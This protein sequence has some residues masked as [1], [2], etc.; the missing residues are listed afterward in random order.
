MPLCSAA[1]SSLHQRSRRCRHRRRR[2]RFSRIDP[3]AQARTYSAT[4]ECGAIRRTAAYP[5]QLDRG[6]RGDWRARRRRAAVFRIPSLENG[7]L[8]RAAI[9]LSGQWECCAAT[10]RRALWRIVGN[11]LVWQE[12]T[13]ERRR[14]K[15]ERCLGT[16]L[17]RRAL[18]GCFAP[19]D[20]AAL[21]RDA[22]GRGSAAC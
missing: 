22:A 13:A 9:S 4:S 16:R 8:I 6:G 17:R 18:P 19:A 14:F 15:T 2:R 10:R 5:S 21:L 3:S 1:H 20:R 7:A 11:R 12:R